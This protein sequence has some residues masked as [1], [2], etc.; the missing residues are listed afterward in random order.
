M[1]DTKVYFAAHCPLTLADAYHC[2]ME[3]PDIGKPTP[4][5]VMIK[6]VE[7]RWAYADAM[8]KHWEKRL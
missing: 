4:E 8:V 5:Q 6:F 7:M 1:V 3:L 2:F